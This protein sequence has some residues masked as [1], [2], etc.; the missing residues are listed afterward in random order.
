M[1]L[2][3]T[4]SS[5]QGTQQNTLDAFGQRAAGHFL[6]SITLCPQNLSQSAR[7]SQPH[8][9]RFRVNDQRSHAEL[10]DLGCLMHSVMP[11]VATLRAVP[12][13]LVSPRPVSTQHSFK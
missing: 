1:P 6:G 7:Q 12:C 13:A 3:M 8:R 2:A 11:R 10:G 4:A 9:A 5:R